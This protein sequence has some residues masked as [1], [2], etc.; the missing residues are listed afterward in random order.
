MVGKNWYIIIN[1]SYKQIEVVND[2]YLKRFNIVISENDKRLIRENA[3][4]TIEIFGWGYLEAY[5]TGEFS[6]LEWYKKEGYDI[7]NR[8]RA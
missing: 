3:N 1:H 7:L 5:E 2:I 8:I 4:N 6:S